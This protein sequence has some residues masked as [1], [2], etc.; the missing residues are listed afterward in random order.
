MPPV[1]GGGPRTLL[2]RLREIMAEQGSAQSRLDK[3]VT[4]IAAN[5]VA[6]VCSMKT[7]L[8]FA[9][10]LFAA[11]AEPESSRQA[12]SRQVSMW[13]SR[14]MGSLFKTAESVRISNVSF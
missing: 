11:S 1:A 5:M 9:P 6:E 8:F 4:V 7:G 13:R 2:R 10:L 12:T 3:L 14:I